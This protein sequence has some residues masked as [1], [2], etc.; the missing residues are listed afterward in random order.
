MTSPGW[1]DVIQSLELAFEGDAGTVIEID[2]IQ[3]YR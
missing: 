3:I 2:A 1:G